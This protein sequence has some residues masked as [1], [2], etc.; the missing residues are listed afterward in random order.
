MVRSA[1][2]ASTAA[3]RDACASKW[4]PASR[5]V[6]PVAR[7]SSAIARARKVRRP[8]QAGAHRGAAQRELGQRRAGGLGAR[9]AELDLTREAAQLLGGAQRRR[10]HQVGAPDLHHVV[11]LGRFSDQAGVQPAQRREQVALDREPPGQV[12]RGRHHVVRGLRA[13]HVVVG[14]DRPLLRAQPIPGQPRDH[15]VRVGV[16]RGPRA[17]LEDVDREVRVVLSLGD[18]ARRLLDRARAR[19]V[20][21]AQLAIRGGRRRLD[22]AQR[23]DQRGWHPLAADREVLDGAL[24]RGAPERAGGHLDLAHRIAL[25]PSLPAAA[26]HA[27]P[28]GRLAS[29]GP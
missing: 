17:G 23:V 18:L 29:A 5:K 11:E 8:V 16:G 12:E 2:L 7:F 1:P 22:Q 14:M 25:D 4:S 15:L 9:D 24:G 28:P 26:R 19:L 6:R 21:H 3:S 13:V 10:V 27:A 20:Q